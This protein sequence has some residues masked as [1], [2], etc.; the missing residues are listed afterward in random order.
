MQLTAPIIAFVGRSESGKT[1]FIERLVPELKGRGYKVATVKHVPQ[2]FHPAA[3]VRDTERHLAA[4]AD[5]TIAAAPGALILT[6]LCSSENPLDEIA[7]LLGDEYD[8][9]IAEGFKSSGIPKFEIWRRGAGTPLED[10]KSRAAVITDDDYPDESARRFRLSEVR[11]VADLIEKGYILPNLER[12]SLN[13]NGESVALSAFPR[14]FTTNIVNALIASLK[15][16][17]PV[18]WLEIRL[19]R[20]GNHAA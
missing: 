4:G 1:T 10:I 20:S 9:I 14:E 3:P 12:I 8:I 19:R 18:K 6:K 5:A 11:E 7:R 16:V 13:V 15:G 17:P 2:H